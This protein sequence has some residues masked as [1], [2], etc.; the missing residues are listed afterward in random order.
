MA[1]LITSP[2][3]PDVDGVYQKLIDSHAGLSDAESIALN[4]RLILLLI[5]QIGDKEAV[6]AAITAA[7]SAGS[8]I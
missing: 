8:N 6:E 7:K 4:A 5:N 3:I 1:K 2:N